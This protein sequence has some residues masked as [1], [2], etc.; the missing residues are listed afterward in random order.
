MPAYDFQCSV[1]GV[2]L[3]YVKEFGDDT[4]PV[5]CSQSMNRVWTPTPAIFRG[6]GWGGS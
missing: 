6:G 4:L 5:C 2:T 3:E 1:C